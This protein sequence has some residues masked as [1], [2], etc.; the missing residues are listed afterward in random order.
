MAVTSMTAI[1]SLRESTSARPL[2]SARTCYDHLAGRLG[3][4]VTQALVDRGA[5]TPTDVLSAFTRAG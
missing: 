4:Q 1:R 2:R 3:V 5:L